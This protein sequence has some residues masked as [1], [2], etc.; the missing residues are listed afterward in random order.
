MLVLWK[1]RVIFVEG[2]EMC[3]KTCIMGTE[4]SF[5]NKLLRCVILKAFCQIFLQEKGNGRS[6]FTVETLA[7]TTVD[8]FLAGTG[9]TSTTLRYGLLILQKYPE[10][11]GNR[12]GKK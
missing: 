6:V 2:H 12:K 9:T 5:L 3:L 11:Q 7:R 4:L 1:V 10:V 8:L